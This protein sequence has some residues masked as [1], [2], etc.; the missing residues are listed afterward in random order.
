MTGLLL[1]MF[2][3][4]LARLPPDGGRHHRLVELARELAQCRAPFPSH[5]A[6]VLAQRV[7]WARRMLEAGGAPRTV[8]R[9]RLAALFGVS[10]RTADRDI[11]RALAVRRARRGD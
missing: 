10:L 1:R 5:R 7:Q 6:I 9:D 4:E 2:V 11:G 8:I 3:D